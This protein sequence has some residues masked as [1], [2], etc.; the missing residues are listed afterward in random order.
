MI[1]V[2]SFI[3]YSVCLDSLI[4]R[5]NRKRLHNISLPVMP[6]VDKNHHAC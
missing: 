1:G 5:G 2:A 4:N 6:L 3:K